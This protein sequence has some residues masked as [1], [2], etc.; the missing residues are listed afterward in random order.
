MADDTADVGPFI[1]AVGDEWTQPLPPG[2]SF[3]LYWQDGGGFFLL[4]AVCNMKGAERAAL[5]AGNIRAY[6]GTTSGGNLVGVF[7]VDKFGQIDAVVANVRVQDFTPEVGRVNAERWQHGGGHGTVTAVFVDRVGA[8]EV[9]SPQPGIVHVET[10]KTQ[11]DVIAAL[12]YFTVSEYVTAY[13]GRQ[14]ARIYSGPVLENDEYAADVLR[15]QADYPKVKD[16]I[17]TAAVS[18]RAGA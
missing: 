2:D 11:T 1:Y 8:L 9:H 17:K 5:S 12:R 14:L 13:V 15:F 7:D 4:G 10:G 18:C 3:G 16:W 6:F